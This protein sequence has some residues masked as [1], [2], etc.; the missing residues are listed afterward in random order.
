M[1][2]WQIASIVAEQ[3]KSADLSLAL[4]LGTPLALCWKSFRRLR[5]S[6]IDNAQSPGEDFPAEKYELEACVSYSDDSSSFL[7]SVQFVLRTF[8]ILQNGGAVFTDARDCACQ[9]CRRSLRKPSRIFICI[10]VF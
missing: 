2:P 1:R 4:H 10:G 3:R 8:V 7:E 9:I 6:R 5:D